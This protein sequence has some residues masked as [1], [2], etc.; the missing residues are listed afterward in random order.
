MYET[1]GVFHSSSC[2][3]A[4]LESGCFLTPEVLR[5]SGKLAFEEQGPWCRPCTEQICS[6][7][8]TGRFSVSESFLKAKTQA[9][10]KEYEKLAIFG[11][12]KARRGAEL[13]AAEER[14]LI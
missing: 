3:T 4:S 8:G 11:N 10:F 1:W 2:W 7:A 13:K 5:G 12:V 9:R 14:R 6:T